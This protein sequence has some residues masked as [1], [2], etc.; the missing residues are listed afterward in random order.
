[1]IPKPI[2][3]ARNFAIIG[4]FFKILFS[5]AD[6]DVRLSVYSQGG[7]RPVPGPG[8]KMARDQLSGIYTALSRYLDIDNATS[9]RRG[10]RFSDF[11]T[12]PPAKSESPRKLP[13]TAFA[14]LQ[15]DRDH[16]PDS[17]VGLNVRRTEVR[18]RRTLRYCALAAITY[19]VIGSYN[20][21]ERD[22]LEQQFRT[23]IHFAQSQAARSY[24]LRRPV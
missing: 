8:R 15:C 7:D 24:H 19:S 12:I 14:R 3:L 2:N 13:S 17:G 10:S 4:L 11:E 9:Q 23:K 18:P 16:C 20:R 1:M 6:D 5:Y 22:G 21:G